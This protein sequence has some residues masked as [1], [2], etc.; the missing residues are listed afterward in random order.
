MVEAGRLRHR[1]TFQEATETYNDVG[2]PVTTWANVKT[3]WAEVKP[4][5]GQEYWASQQVNAEV[6][7]RVTVRYMDGLDSLMRIKFGDRYFSIEPPINPDERDIELQ[8][9]CKESV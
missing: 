1:I 7:H 8:M 3:V 9:L 6:T 2:E 5:K 4:I